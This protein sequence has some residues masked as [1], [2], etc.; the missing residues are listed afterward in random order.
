[1]NDDD[2]FDLEQAL[3]GLGER[4]TK[5]AE[6]VGGK[7]RLA[8]AIRISESQLYRY[9]AGDSQPTIEPLAAIAKSGNVDLNWLVLGERS[10][11]LPPQI[12]DIKGLYSSK[13]EYINIPEY[14]PEGDEIDNQPVSEMGRLSFNHFWL[15]KL[16]LDISQLRLL[17]AHGDAMAPTLHDGDLLMLDT[18]QTAFNGD[19]IYALN[20]EPQCC[21]V[22]R[23]QQ[24]V[25]QGVY[26]VSDNPAYREQHVPSADIDNL[27]IVGKVVWTAGVM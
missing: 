8:Q 22:K 12:N 7:K 25:D 14:L 2:K 6:L 23:L 24:A 1:M 10:S 15:L 5:V 17:R 26:I 27:D 3:E 19:A 18:G 9:I 21:T 11:G 16:G 4:I 20:L 13:Q